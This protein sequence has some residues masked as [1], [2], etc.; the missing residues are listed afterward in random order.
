[1]SSCHIELTAKASDYINRLIAKENGKGFRLSVKK[2]GCSGYSYAPTVA[3]EPKATDIVITNAADFPIY[4]DAAYIDLLAELHIDLLEENNRGLKQ[5]KLI[6]SNPKES[7]RCG[8]GE[9]FH[10]ND[11]NEVT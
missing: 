11:S 10:V 9:S 3:K 5:I 1:M 7:A 2:T 8:C 4:I 6:F